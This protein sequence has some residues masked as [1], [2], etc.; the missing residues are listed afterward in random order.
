[1]PTG[2]HFRR[3]CWPH[4]AALTL[5]WCWVLR[6]A[7]LASGKFATERLSV[8][9]RLTMDRFTEGG[10]EYGE[11]SK[12]W[13]GVG[14]WVCLSSS[15]TV[16]Q[17]SDCHVCC[18]HWN[19]EFMVNLENQW[20]SV[21]PHGLLLTCGSLV[22]MTD[23]VSTINW[24]YYTIQAYVNSIVFQDHWQY[25]WQVSHWGDDWNDLFVTMS[26]SASIIGVS[27]NRD[28]K[29][30][31]LYESWWVINHPSLGFPILRTAQYIRSFEWKGTAHRKRTRST[32]AG[33][34][35]TW[36]MGKPG[37]CWLIPSCGS[38]WWVVRIKLLGFVCCDWQRCRTGSW[39]Q[40]YP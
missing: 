7:A 33:K 34:S 31:P 27:Q 16:L 21:Y 36:F 24:S 22:S 38:K 14:V 10:N 15:S 39:A 25:H 19:S 8:L 40:R 17:N 23:V 30:Y 13:Q 18:L 37:R 26:S 3:D 2:I 29:N 20:I 28:P 6:R 11:C 4:C 32:S 5:C 12:S 1:M 35:L 9:S